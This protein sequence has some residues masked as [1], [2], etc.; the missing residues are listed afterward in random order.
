MKKYLILSIAIWIASMASAQKLEY[1][2]SSMGLKVADLSM[3]VS[4][5]RIYVKASN[6]GYKTIFPHLNNSYSVYLGEDYLPQKYIRMIH[7]DSLKDSV[8]VIYQHG[9]A[10][11]YRKS[12]KQRFSYNMPAN[13]RDVFSLLWKVCQSPKPIGDYIV[14]GN[15]RAW[16]VSVSGGEIEKLKTS[17]GKFQT[18]KYELRFKALSPHKAAYVDMLTHNFLNEDVQLSLWVNQG[19]I[20]VKARLRKKLMS[21]SWEIISIS[22]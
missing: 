1:Q 5:S 10:V 6:N 18:T 14:D 2:I 17:L 22:G 7:Q 11:M 21:M 3:H 9:S 8:N 20:P 16:N 19:G 13:G 15:G 12:S 4:P